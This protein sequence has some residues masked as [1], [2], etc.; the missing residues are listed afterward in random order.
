MAI[1]LES[2]QAV[3]IAVE[4]HISA[5]YCGHRPLISGVVPVLRDCGRISLSKEAMSEAMPA[6]TL[7]EHLC[8]C[9]L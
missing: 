3:Q 2:E 7:L 9:A 5:I 1:H 8:R 6:W 4:T